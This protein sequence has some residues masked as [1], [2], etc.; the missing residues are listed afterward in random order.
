VVVVIGEAQSAE[1]LQ[2]VAGRAKDI[3]GFVGKDY[4]W[5]TVGVAEPSERGGHTLTDT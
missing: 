3:V 4:D 5:V 1:R 2:V